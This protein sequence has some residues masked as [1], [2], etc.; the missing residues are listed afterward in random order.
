MGQ[1]ERFLESKQAS[2][3]LE[4]AL[5]EYFLPGLSDTVRE[6][7]RAYLRL[8][9]RPAM[10]AL[11]STEELQ[12]LGILEEQGFFSGALVDHGLEYAIQ[13]GKNEV[14]ILFFQWKSEKYGFH[15]PDFSL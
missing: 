3:K 5:E 8:R 1:Y 7:Y 14:L 12:K 4:I 15:R 6:A 11:I 2:V 13:K 10:E 9:I